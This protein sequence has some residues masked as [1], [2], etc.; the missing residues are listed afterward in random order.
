MGILRELYVKNTTNKIFRIYRGPR[1]K[2]YV[3][4]VGPN[5]FS[6]FPFNDPTGSS[7]LRAV[8]DDGSPNIDKVVSGTPMDYTWQLKP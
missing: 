4:R 7:Y 6:G 1:H 8:P 3:G 2:K 5:S